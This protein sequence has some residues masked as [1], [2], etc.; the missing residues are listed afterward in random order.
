MKTKKLYFI[1]QAAMIAA[2]YIVMTMF[3]NTFNL[4]SGTIQIRVSEALTVLPFFTPAAVPGLFIG[5][6]LSNLLTGAMLPD[7]IFGSLATLLGA[8]GS[9]ALRKHSF[10]VTLPPVIANLVLIPFVLHGVDISIPFQAL[11][12]GAGEVITCCI[13]GS[14]LIKA[15]TPYRHLIF[16]SDGDSEKQPIA[17]N[18]AVRHK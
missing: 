9:Y 3:I 16:Q 18:N 6:L 12:V 5:C 7:V 13:L 15:L 8:L 10:L 2:I 11:T 17:A 4:A 14:V 1:T